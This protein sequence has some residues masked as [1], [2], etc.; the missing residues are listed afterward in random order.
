MDRQL[1][2]P[3]GG[4]GELD[5]LLDAIY[6]VYHHDFRNYAESSVRRRIQAALVHLPLEPSQVVECCEA[7]PSLPASIG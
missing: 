4:N 7:W 1:T 6:R 5:A 2:A 3:A